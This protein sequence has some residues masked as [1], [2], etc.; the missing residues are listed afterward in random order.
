MKKLFLITTVMALGLTANAAI[1]TVNCSGL[2]IT[3]AGTITLTCGSFGAVA[4]NNG[5]TLSGFTANLIGN[6]TDGFGGVNH[7][8]SYAFTFA[9]PLTLITTLSSTVS[10]G[11]TG[12]TGATNGVA[13]AGASQVS[14]FTPGNISVVV[15]A[16]SGTAFPNASATAQVQILANQAATI[17]E[18]S[19]F[20]LLGSALLGLGALAGRRRL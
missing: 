1:L 2:G 9:S 18:P 14:N 7:A 5:T 13:V 11:P 6:W 16:I 15:S 8:F 19:T 12:S 4:G 17:P 20:A 10:N 3:S